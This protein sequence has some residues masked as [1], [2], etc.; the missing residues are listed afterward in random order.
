[1]KVGVSI[2]GH[3]SSLEDLVDLGVRAEAAGVESIWLGEYFRNAYVVATLLGQ[4]T[5]RVR[6]GTAIALAFTRSPLTTALAALDVDEATGHRFV[7]GLGSQVRRGIENWH[8][9]EY[10]SRPAARMAECVGAVR[11]AMRTHEETPQTYNGEYYKIDLTGFQR[12]PAPQR[13][14]PIYVAAVHAGMIRAAV[15]VGDGVIGH[16]FWSDRYLADVVSPLLEDCPDRFERS[17]TLL[18]AVHQDAGVARRDA[19]RTLAYY[20][21]TRTYFDII[22]ADGFAEEAEACRAAT[23]GG[24]LQAMESAVSD[25]MLDTYAVAGSP[26]ELGDRLYAREGQLDLSILIPAYFGTP[27][28]RITEEYETLLEAMSARP[29]AAGTAPS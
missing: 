23:Q 11:V 29:L 7:L 8:G 26:D 1:V 22:E 24:N 20:A 3:E 9:L 14:V 6:I 15:K 19:K 2:F 10:G 13:A 12:K 18:C 27:P 25:A 4:R 28:S 21:S 16:V 5:E 17:A